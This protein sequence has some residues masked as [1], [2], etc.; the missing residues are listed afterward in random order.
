MDILYENLAVVKSLLNLLNVNMHIMVFFSA[1]VSQIY[2][3]IE[4]EL[5]IEKPVFNRL[6]E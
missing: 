5:I 1:K 2:S 4:R 3:S 6:W